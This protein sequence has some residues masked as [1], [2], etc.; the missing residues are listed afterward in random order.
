M[1]D[2]HKPLIAVR[3]L[4]EE[5]NRVTFGHTPEDNCTENVGSGK[6]VSMK[7]KGTGAHMLELDMIGKSGNVEVC[8]DRGA[9]ESVCPVA[10]GGDFPS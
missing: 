9:E 5:G 2:V 8:V 4:V 3:R 1:A 6:I 10:R 7:Q